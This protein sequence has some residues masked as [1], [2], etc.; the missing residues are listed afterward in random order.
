MPPPSRK[1]ARSP[2]AA[3]TENE[4]E[5]RKAT[6]LAVR[7][8]ERNEGAREE[9]VRVKWFWFVQL[10]VP[11]CVPLLSGRVSKTKA[12]HCLSSRG[13]PSVGMDR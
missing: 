4:K 2:G 13:E 11:T 7:S 10:L 1:L 6:T 9:E 8:S 3:E 12:E 5:G